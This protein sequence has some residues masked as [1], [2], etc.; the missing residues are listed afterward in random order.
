MITSFMPNAN[1]VKQT[2]SFG[3]WFGPGDINDKKKQAI[4]VAVGEIDPATASDMQRRGF[5]FHSGEKA[6]EKFFHDASP[7]TCARYLIDRY[8]KES[9]RRGW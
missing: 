5:K 3:S 1:L 6:I 9:K 8:K 4:R 2:T 7:D